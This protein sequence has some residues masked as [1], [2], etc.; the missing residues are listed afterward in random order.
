[1]HLYPNTGKA[2]VMFGNLTSYPVE[3][4]T[5]ALLTSGTGPP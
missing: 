1:M 4:L 3:Q 2:V 5:A